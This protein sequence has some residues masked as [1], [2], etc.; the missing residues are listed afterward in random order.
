MA[1][2][3]TP[4]Y[5]ALQISGTPKPGTGARIIKN[6]SRSGFLNTDT[7]AS[8]DQGLSGAKTERWHRI[9]GTTWFADQFS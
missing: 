7:T 6:Q 9:A 4:D 8:R 3:V 1:L 5:E 2:L